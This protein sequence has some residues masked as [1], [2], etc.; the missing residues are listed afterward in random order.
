MDTQIKVDPAQYAYVGE[1]GHPGTEKLDT[2]DGTPGHLR[3]RSLT[4]K[5]Q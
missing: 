5:A 1:V 4:L 2:C 3:R